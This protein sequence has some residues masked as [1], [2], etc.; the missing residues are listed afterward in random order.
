[1][2]TKKGYAI[3]F[4]ILLLLGCSKEKIEN[5]PAPKVVSSQGIQTFTAKPARVLVL[6]RFPGNVAPKVTA[7]ISSKSAGYLKEIT[8]DEGDPVIKDQLLRFLVV[9]WIRTSEPSIECWC[10]GMACVDSIGII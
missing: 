8:V 5:P 2:R 6:R 4:G 9:V 7:F 1:M 10:S 3:I